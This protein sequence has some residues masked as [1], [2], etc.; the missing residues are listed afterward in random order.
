V[1]QVYVLQFGWWWSAVYSI[2]LIIVPL[3]WIIFKL[4]AAQSPA[5]YHRL[6]SVIKYVMFAGILSMLVFRIYT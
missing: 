5:D 4:H 2:V 6:S 1:V 3:I